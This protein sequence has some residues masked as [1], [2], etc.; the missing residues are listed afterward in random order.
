MFYQLFV[1]KQAV[2]A[3]LVYFDLFNPAG[4]TKR[5][6]IHSVRPIVSTA[7]A[8][9]GTLGVDLVLT[10]TSAVG[11]GGT[12]ATA[13]GTDIAAATISCFNHNQPIS[14]ITARLTPTGGATAG[15]VIAARCVM[16]EEAAGNALVQVMDFV[17]NDFSDLPPL[18]VPEGTGIRI[19]QGVVASVGNIGF[20]VIFS[21]TPSA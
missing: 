19:V 10:R 3:S 17:R 9:A 2:G 18:L 7:V 20:D 8:V 11:T 15:A 21:L 4:S 13:N 1:P 12:A 14:A 16:T 5:V 6:H